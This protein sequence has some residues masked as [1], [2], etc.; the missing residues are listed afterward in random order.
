[1]PVAVKERATVPFESFGR[2]DVWVV[3][4]GVPGAPATIWVDS[5]TRAV[6]RVQYDIATRRMRMTDERETR[7]P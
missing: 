2:R 5:A 3:T 1:M 4:V 6:L 7:L